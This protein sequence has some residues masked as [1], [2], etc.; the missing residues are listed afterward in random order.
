MKYEVGQSFTGNLMKNHERFFVMN[1]LAFR[2]KVFL[3]G[4]TESP[5]EFL[6]DVPPKNP[7]EVRRAFL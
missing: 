7:P 4:F 5:L 3:L 2:T 6:P 1:L